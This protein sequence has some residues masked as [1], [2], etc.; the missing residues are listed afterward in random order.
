M[1]RSLITIASLGLQ[2]GCSFTLQGP[3]SVD[4]DEVVQ[5]TALESEVGPDPSQKV[6]VH[7][8][9]EH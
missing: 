5:E 7:G 8:N 3:A 4:V 1:T 2:S 9:D 6:A